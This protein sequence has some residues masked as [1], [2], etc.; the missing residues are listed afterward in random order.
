M[1]NNYIKNI[2]KLNMIFIYKNRSI[3][4]YVFNKLLCNIKIYINNKPKYLS[5]RLYHYLYVLIIIRSFGLI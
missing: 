1:K 2:N 3:S 4:I 5:I